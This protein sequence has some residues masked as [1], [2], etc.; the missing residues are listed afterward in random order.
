MSLIRYSDQNITVVCDNKCGREYS[1]ITDDPGI[2]RD[3]VRIARRWA[4]VVDGNETRDYCGICH[5]EMRERA[6]RKAAGLNY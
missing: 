4:S 5:V 3:A 1:V 2:A 6:V